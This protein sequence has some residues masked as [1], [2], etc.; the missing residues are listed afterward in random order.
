VITLE[1]VLTG[2]LNGLGEY[3]EAS[4]GHRQEFGLVRNSD[5]DWRISRP[6]EGLLI[7]RYHFE[8]NY[9][10]L[11]LHFMDPTGSVLVSDRRHVAQNVLT[12]QLVADMQLAGPGEWLAPVVRPA[13]WARSVLDD[14]VELLPQGVAVLHLGS[15]A[16]ELSEEQLSILMAEFTTT[17][18][19]LP[20]VAAVQFSLGSTLLSRPGTST[21]TLTAADFADLAAGRAGGQLLTVRENVVYPIQAR[22]PWSEGEPIGDGLT[23]PGAI[24]ARSDLAEIAAVD[25]ERTRLTVSTGSDPEIELRVGER[26]LLRPDYSP[27]NELWTIGDDAGA[28]GFVVFG[29]DDHQ[30]V[31]VTAAP[32][33]PA[34]AVR[35]YRISPDGTR[36]ALV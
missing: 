30:P 1:A 11:F 36:I 12:P 21:V 6:P 34:D 26:R 15:A 27:L 9:T 31:P 5:G 28:S 33:L 16:A 10:V 22:E 13:P 7:S 3:R 23:A 2:G 17:L 19:A 18:T 25:P 24:A 32:D 20:Q 4:G 29:A 35:A 8:T 14:E